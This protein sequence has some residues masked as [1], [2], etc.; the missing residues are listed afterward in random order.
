MLML[1]IR[2]NTNDAKYNAFVFKRLY[3]K[4]I[5]HKTWWV[6]SVCVIISIKSLKNYIP[7]EESVIMVLIYCCN[8]FATKKCFYK[9]EILL[10][11][12]KESCLYTQNA[13]VCAEVIFCFLYICKQEHLLWTSSLFVDLWRIHDICSHTVLSSFDQLGTFMHDIMLKYQ[14]HSW[15]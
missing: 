13:A 4:T 6:S 5:R 1:V 7:T 12:D 8:K 9:I 2:H 11:T 14:N 15:K 3:C 10:I